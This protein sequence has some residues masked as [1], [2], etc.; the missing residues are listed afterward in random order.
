MMIL[1]QLKIIDFM[2]IP[3]TQLTDQVK[4]IQQIYIIEQNMKIE[5]LEI[6]V[7]T[8]KND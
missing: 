2:I 4:M 3:K 5:K 8:L 7:K 6:E 1:S